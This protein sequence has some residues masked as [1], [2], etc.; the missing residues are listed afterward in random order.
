MSSA[1]LDGGFDTVIERRAERS[2]SGN[3][4]SEYSQH[5]VEERLIKKGLEYKNNLNHK[6]HEAIQDLIKD[7]PCFQPK[8]ISNNEQYLKDD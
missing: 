5:A 7:G 2:K 4:L 6:R 3:R 8:L 1:G